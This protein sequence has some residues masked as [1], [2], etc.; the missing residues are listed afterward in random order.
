MKQ[1]IQTEQSKKQKIRH[2]TPNLT[3]VKD[4]IEIEIKGKGR[5]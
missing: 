4:Q 5:Y 2:Q 1:K 3:F